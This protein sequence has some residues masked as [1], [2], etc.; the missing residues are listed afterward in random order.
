MG[1]VLAMVENSCKTIARVA[2]AVA[3]VIN[4]GTFVAGWRTLYIKKKKKLFLIL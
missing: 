1:G 4:N 3:D 2:D